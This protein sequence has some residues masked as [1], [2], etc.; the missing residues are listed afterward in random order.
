[1]RVA[2]AWAGSPVA[3]TKFERNAIEIPRYAQIE[4]SF[5]DDVQSMVG[6]YLVGSIDE[7]ELRAAF[8]NRLWDAETESFVAGRRARGDVRRLVSEAEAAML[9]VRHERNVRYFRKFVEDMKA[10]RGRM[11]YL[12]RAGLYANSLWSLFSRGESVDWDDPEAANAR[13]HWVLDPEAEHCQDCLDRAKRSREQ[14]GFS[15]EELSALGWPGENTEC[16]TS[17]RCHI[18]VVRKKLLLPERIEDLGPAPSPTAGIK[19]LEELLG[20]E[21]M[22]LKIPGAGVPYVSIAPAVVHEALRR[23]HDPDRLAKH[24]P[25]LP[26]VLVKPSTVLERPAVRVYEGYGLRAAIERSSDGLWALAALELK[27]KRKEAA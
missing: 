17:C 4:A 10:G 21:E 24:L 19:T 15:W 6:R 3:R 18:R 5:R 2:P 14:D 23:S 20:G 1:M 11:D 26:K 8:K 9:Q 7:H 16:M 25:V 12:R 22:P 13:Y 27:A